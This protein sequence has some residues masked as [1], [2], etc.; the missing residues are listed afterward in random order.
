MVTHSSILAWR[1]P[2]TEEPGGLQSMGLQRV[3]HNLAPEHTH[4]HKICMPKGKFQFSSKDCLHQ[5][6]RTFSK[7]EWEVRQAPCTFS[8]FQLE[9]LLMPRGKRVSLSESPSFHHHHPQ[10]ALPTS[11][12]LSFLLREGP[13]SAVDFAK[14]KATGE[15]R[16][17]RTFSFT[18]EAVTVVSLAR[19]KCHGHPPAASNSLTRGRQRLSLRQ[20][21]TARTLAPK[22]TWKSSLLNEERFPQEKD[23]GQGGWGMV[24][25]GLSQK[26]Q[27]SPAHVSLRQRERVKYPTIPQPPMCP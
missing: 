9:C 6:E 1:N 13:N 2:W 14:N 17:C 16:C 18:E 11:P 20:T 3:R 5:E 10:N 26:R 12:S 27:K 24:V 21:L 25:S 15:A 7:A 4:T 22:K 8:K 23:G 19:Q